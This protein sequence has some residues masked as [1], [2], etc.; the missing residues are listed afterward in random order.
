MRP[1]LLG[2]LERGEIRAKRPNVNRCLFSLPFFVL[3]GVSLAP[4][5]PAG[6]RGFLLPFTGHEHRPRDGDGDPIQCYLQWNC[7][8]LL[9]GR[10]SGP[11]LGPHW[12]FSRGVRLTSV[13]GPLQRCFRSGEEGGGESPNTLHSILG[14][15]AEQW[16]GRE[17]VLA[18]L[19][20]S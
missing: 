5:L 18:S 7:N 8:I 6:G 17:R 16:E 13:H 1:P 20:V 10:R 11:D 19:S 2:N 14:R 12:R 3:P 15:S 4:L 9:P